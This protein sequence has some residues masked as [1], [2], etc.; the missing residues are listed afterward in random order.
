MR[1]TEEQIAAAKAVAAK[2][3]RQALLLEVEDFDIAVMFR[4]LSPDEFAEWFDVTNQNRENGVSLL[5][6]KC[7]LWP[8][9]DEAR[10][11]MPAIGE[12]ITGLVLERAG[13][14]R[15]AALVEP[16]TVERMVLEGIPQADAAELVAAN[17]RKN[18][19]SLLR[20][21]AQ[22][23]KV[24]MARPSAE[25]FDATRDGEAQAKAD[26]VGLYAVALHAVRDAIVWSS[27]PLET[28]LDRVP[29]ILLDLKKE[30]MRL[31]GAGAKRTI[32]S[33]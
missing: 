6:A 31:G 11:V 15:A 12:E 24:V 9:I 33:L 22:G 27:E 17:P 14:V 21:P 19:L 23:V 28:T 5:L 29:G 8:S 16:A 18:S 7:L 2:V 10:A 13:V 26:G 20:M 30:T 4:D 32:K 1:P 3:D 25:S